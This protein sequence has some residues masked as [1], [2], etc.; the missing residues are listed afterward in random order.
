[1]V[2]AL[3]VCKPVCAQNHKNL[4]KK[5]ASK[6]HWQARYVDYGD[7]A[8]EFHFDQL[9]A[10]VVLVGL[11]TTIMTTPAL[12]R[13]IDLSARNRVLEKALPEEPLGDYLQYV[14]PVAAYALNV[15]GL[16]GKHSYLDATVIL[17]TSWATMGAL[18]NT[19]KYSVRRLRPDASNRKSFVSGHTATAFMGAEFLRREYW[20]TAPIVGILGYTFASFVGVSRVW[21][22]RHW[23]SDVIAGAGVGIFS[24][25]AAYWLFPPLQRL[26]YGV[27]KDGTPRRNYVACASPWYDGNCGGASFS[28]LF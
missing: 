19:I 9:V 13:A 1:M 26:I 12:H 22:N 18:T 14:S 16:K 3:G 5:N 23:V 20:D 28:L 8:S 7:R 6:E 17:A 4:L 11:G 25:Q 21:N 2:L 24:V 10:P 27:R 15:A